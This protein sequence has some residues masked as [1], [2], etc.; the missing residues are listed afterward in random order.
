MTTEEFEREFHSRTVAYQ[1][2][3]RGD[4]RPVV[5]VV[6]DEAHTVAGH[7]LLSALMNQLARA[8]RRLV[9]VGDLEVPLLCADPFGTRT[10]AEATVGLAAAINPGITVDVVEARPDTEAIITLHLGRGPGDLQLGC[11]G[12]RALS[13][14]QVAIGGGAGDIWGAMLASCLGSWA[15]FAR[16]LGDD[17][18]LAD[19]YSLWDFGDS[20][21]GEGT[22]VDG[23]LDVGRVLQ[24][25]VGGVGAALD[26]WLGLAGLSGSWTL[27][28]GDC[29]E[30]SNLNRQ[31]S[32][33]AA[34]AGYPDRHPL[35]KA[36]AGARRLGP[37]ATASPAWFG[38]DKAVVEDTYDVVLPLANERGVRPAVQDRQSPVLLHATTSANYQAQL[39]RHI[40]GRDDCIRCRLPGDAPQLGCSKVALDDTG[41]SDAALP[42]LS[43]A[44]GLLLATGL[45]RLA[46]GALEASD[47]NL[48]AI[49]F[50]GKVPGAQRLRLA[51]R[52]GCRSWAST[53]VRADAGAG[54]RYI[55]L[56][57]PREGVE[58]TAKLA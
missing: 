7:V 41:E 32:F 40:G 30:V 58:R 18:R 21:G 44:A 46:D 16:L 55:D 50:A 13:G 48:F 37:V 25:G 36:E 9:V 33:V 19:S 22:R 14:E 47:R 27:V 28:D 52:D 20:A 12:W 4:D 17:P 2:R 56:A 43:G 53:E 42:F 11:S 57:C 26:Y 35:N 31:L 5:V 3:F 8:H 29:V 15:A 51:C 10:L 24:V 1:P 39:H 38:E 6:S 49:D 54:T 23:P 34:D 45:V